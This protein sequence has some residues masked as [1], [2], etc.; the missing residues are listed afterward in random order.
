MRH[1]LL[2]LLLPSPCAA[3]DVALFEGLGSV[4]SWASDVN[5]DGSVI[6]GTTGSPEGRQA[7]HWEGGVMVGLGYL[8]EGTFS[9]AHSV[10]D[11]GSAVVG[12]G[13]TN[14]E[15]FR[16][17]GIMQGL[18][19]FGVSGQVECCIVDRNNPLVAKHPLPIEDELV[20]GNFYSWREQWPFL[21]RNGGC[22][23]KQCG[24]TG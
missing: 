1:F 7:F 16:W 10:S 19:G 22:C 21:P 5:A 4:P 24:Q 20:T 8:S 18:G 14:R 13:G 9:Y 3:A 17:D 2:L 23:Q 15:A 12:D 6:V 11:D